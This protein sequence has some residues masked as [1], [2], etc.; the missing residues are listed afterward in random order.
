[1]NFIIDSLYITAIL[2]FS[3]GIISIAHPE[4]V[5]KVPQSATALPSVQVTPLHDE[6]E[7]EFLPDATVQIVD[8]EI[9]IEYI[10]Q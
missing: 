5:S 7:I 6:I 2:V 4:L 8:A 3:G 1:M 9:S 10:S